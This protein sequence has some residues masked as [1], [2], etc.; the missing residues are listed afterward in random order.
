MNHLTALWVQVLLV[1]LVSLRSE[2]FSPNMVTKRYYSTTCKSTT[3]SSSKQQLARLH[4]CI[5]VRFDDNPIE[6]T[7]HVT[8]RE[9]RRNAIRHCE[10]YSKTLWYSW[11]MQF[12]PPWWPARL[13]PKPCAKAGIRNYL[14]PASGYM[15]EVIRD[16]FKN[17]T[18]TNSSRISIG[19][20][21]YMW[22]K[23]TLRGRQIGDYLLLR[24][25]Q[26]LRRLHATHMLL[27]HD[28]NG[29]RKL[30]EYYQTRGFDPIFSYLDKGMIG[31]L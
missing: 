12:L 20:L 21:V 28:D 18:S 7:F 3:S 10:L 23:P 31:K 22:I 14:T 29:S 24:C 1:L 8:E 25:V 19:I 27:V 9:D 26:T 2:A 15:E 16:L 13:R 5:D 30:I 11:L 6:T 17:E 4:P